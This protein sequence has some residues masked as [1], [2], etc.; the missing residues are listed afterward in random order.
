MAEDT[1]SKTSTSH[2]PIRLLITSLRDQV[3][4][5]ARSFVSANKHSSYR[6][7]RH[8]PQRQLDIQLLYD[9][10]VL[11]YLKTMPPGALIVDIGTGRECRFARRRPSGTTARV[12]GVDSAAE[13]VAQNRDVDE[14]RVADVSLGV[15]FNDGEVDMIVSRSVLEHL[16]DSDAFVRETARVLR[17]GGYSIHLFASKFAPFAILNQLLPKKITSV[18]LNSL[19]PECKGQLGFRSHY[20]QT[21]CSRMESL[22]EAHGFEVRWSTVS[23]YQSGYY[24]FFL[25]LY[26]LSALYE[27]I[28]YN[29]NIRTLAAKVLIVAQKQT[30]PNAQ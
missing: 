15:P 28:I 8:L 14:K 7:E 29:L 5:A 4:S 20:D 12:I 22:F 25:P 24:N 27:L 19:H 16:A 3:A 23:Y 1:P 10:A 26:L 13:E 18:L 21:Y 9:N 17:T 6:I 11:H 2:H 30:G